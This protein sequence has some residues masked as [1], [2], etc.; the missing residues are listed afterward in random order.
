MVTE[1]FKIWIPCGQEDTEA[2]PRRKD[3]RRGIQLETV[4]E[5]VVI[6]TRLE[7]TFIERIAKTVE[8][9]KRGR[10]RERD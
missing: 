2:L 5:V 10:E 3:A 1:D 4:A 6:D 9:L 8:L 7:L